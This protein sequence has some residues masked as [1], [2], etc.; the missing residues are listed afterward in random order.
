[1]RGK[2]SDGSWK[3]PFIPWS[4][5]GFTEGNAWQYTF[6]V[7]HDVRGLVNLMG[8]REA[9]IHKLDTVFQNGQYKH[10]NEPSH[11]LAYLYDYA[12]AP[13][14]TQHRVREVM[15][16]LYRATP[17]GLCGNDGCGQMSAWYVFSAMGFYP[18]CPG[19]PYYAIGSPTFEK[20]VIHL[21]PYWDNKSFTVIAKNNSPENKYIQSAT[22][23]GKPLNKP[24]IE[25]SDIV[26]GGT[27]IFEMGPEPDK[28][29]GSS[30]KCAPP[31]MTEL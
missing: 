24:W 11:H 2:N 23:N 20:V 5:K 9:F 29:W 14:K 13:W 3:R 19:A 30:P 15:D 8:G 10:E 22:L 28:T 27:L 12:G 17:G 31:L 4:R 6:F 7:P 21:G 16:E 25:H 18:V 26:N 1:M